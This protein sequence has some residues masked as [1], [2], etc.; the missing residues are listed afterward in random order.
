MFPSKT[1]ATLVKT[2]N[3]TMITKRRNQGASMESKMYCAFKIHYF[4]I[5]TH[6]HIR[7]ANAIP[8]QYFVDHHAFFMH[9]KVN[10]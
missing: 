4:H 9:V 3:N 7:V 5:H 1:Y 8:V 10:L 2:I 6:W